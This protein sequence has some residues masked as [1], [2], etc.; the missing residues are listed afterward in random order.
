MQPGDGVFIYVDEPSMTYVEDGR[1][2]R[3]GSPETM[4]A[5]I[6]EA[7]ARGYQRAIDA[8]Q[9]EGRQRQV[10]PSMPVTYMQGFWGAV[11]HLKSLSSQPAEETTDG[12]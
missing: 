4:A 1:T 9:A 11:D 12:Q 10:L 8:L 5:E 6:R 7:E 2:Y 3:I